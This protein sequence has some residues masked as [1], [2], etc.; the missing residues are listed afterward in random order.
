M[1]PTKNNFIRSYIVFINNKNISETHEVMIKIIFLNK[2]LKKN[3]S[4]LEMFRKSSNQY[5]MK[6]KYSSSTSQM[7]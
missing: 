6:S 2:K 3:Q 1:N 5:T 7:K 4:Q